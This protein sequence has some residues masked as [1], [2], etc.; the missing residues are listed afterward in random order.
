MSTSVPSAA[1]FEEGVKRANRVAGFVLRVP[2]GMHTS[3]DVVSAFI[4]KQIKA[5]RTLGEIEA[6]LSGPK[7]HKYLTNMK[8]D[9][10][11]LEQA[12]KRG[13]DAPRV[14]FDEAEPILWEILE[15][16]GTVR[17][18]DVTDEIEFGAETDNPEAVLVRKEKDTEMRNFLARLLEKV[19][20]SA[21]QARIIELDQKGFTNE[22]IAREVGVD[23]KTVYSRR[24]EAHRKLASAAKRMIQHGK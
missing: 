11:R 7:I 10:V 15:G 8:N 16:S 4:E 14:S 24:S 9:I 22:E 20:L 2:L 13:S 17:P 12:F 5:G 18:P 6:M 19:N 1:T 23:V 3:E 21:L